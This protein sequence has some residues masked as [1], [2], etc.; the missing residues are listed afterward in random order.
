MRGNS[1]ILY[2]NPNSDAHILQ[3][4]F[5]LSRNRLKVFYILDCGNPTSPTGYAVETTPAS[6]IE[7]ATASVGC[8]TGYNEVSGAP[9]SITCQADGS[10]TAPSGCQG[11]DS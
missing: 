7:D 3:I 9:P 2:N 4:S 10:W 6:T 5:F 11:V 1:F 8:A